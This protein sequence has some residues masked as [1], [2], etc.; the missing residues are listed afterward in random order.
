MAYYNNAED[1]EQVQDPNAAP[2]PQQGQQGGSV[3]SGQGAGGASG[4]T[5]PNTPAA[6]SGDSSGP[7]NFVGI[8]T[9]LDANKPQ[10]TKLAQDTAGLVNTATQQARD[11]IPQQTELYNQAVDQNT[12]K[13][14]Q[15]VF[16]EAKARAERVAADAAKK[17]S[18]VKMRDAQYGGPTSLQTSEFYQPIQQ[19]FDKATTAGEN[20]KTEEGQA[21]LLADLQQQTRGR[22]NQSAIN[23]D[24]MLLKNDQSRNILQESV[25]NQKDLPDILKTANE[26][27]LA[28]ALEGQNVTDATRNTIAQAF[29]GKNSVQN[30]LQNSIASKLTAEKAKQEALQKSIT[31][32]LNSNAPLT[33]SEAKYLGL[34]PA[35]VKKYQDALNNYNTNIIG[36]REDKAINLADFGD[37]AKDRGISVSNFLQVDP[38]KLN[39]TG[40]TYA[41]PE[42]HARYAALNELMGTSN[43]YLNNAKLSGKA[44][45]TLNF[46]YDAAMEHIN[47]MTRAAQ[48]DLKNLI[49]RRANRLGSSSSAEEDKNAIKDGAVKGAVIGGTV[50]GP[51]GAAAGAIIGAAAGGFCFIANTPILMADGSYKA[52]QLLKI[53]DDTAIGGKVT[54]HGVATTDSIVEYK[55]RFTSP[56]HT[57]FNGESWV[58]AEDLTEGTMLDTAEL[59]MPEG[60]LVYPVSTEFHRLITDN[61]VLYADYEEL[62][63]SSDLTDEEIIEQMNKSVALGA[64]KLCHETLKSKSGAGFFEAAVEGIN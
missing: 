53:G 18:F 15:P 41:T 26:Q 29:T 43:G 38:F 44:V 64:D 57:I 52:V 54:F 21:K 20:T 34:T 32:K 11:T 46:N 56:S 51:A 37:E 7:S 9:Y 14:D 35:Q 59:D 5:T 40:N 48:T 8:K 33:T 2:T 10:S 63:A 24:K 4:P 61:D 28:K 42:E 31:K 39:N 25:N 36:S 58:R 47:S 30:N 19:S 55:G 45:D 49:D 3:I 13:L 17:A 16:D 27:S 22:V 6:A 1:E 23:L 50:G 12:V 62:D 60:I